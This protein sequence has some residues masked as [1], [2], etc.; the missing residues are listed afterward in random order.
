M[1]LPCISL[2]NIAIIAI[3]NKMCIIDPALYAKNPIAHK[4]IKI[5]ATVYNIL[6]M[7]SKF[8]NFSISFCN[9]SLDFPKVI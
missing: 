8:Y 3:T 9:S 6:L 2:N 4:M 5:T 1:L 7:I